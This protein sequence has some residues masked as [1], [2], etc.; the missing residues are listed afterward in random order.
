MATSF[1]TAGSESSEVT[2]STAASTLPPSEILRVSPGKYAGEAIQDV[3]DSES[4]GDDASGEQS[5]SE[6]DSQ[7]DSDDDDDSQSESDSDDDSQSDDEW[8]FWILK[9]KQMKADAERNWHHDT[10]QDKSDPEDEEAAAEDRFIDNETAVNTDLQEDAEEVT[11]KAVQDSDGY[12][13][14]SEGEGDDEWDS[15][16][17]EAKR[18][19]AEVERNW[20]WYPEDSTLKEE[21]ADERVINIEAAVN[22]DWQ[23]NA[24]EVVKVVQ[25]ND[26]IVGDEDEWNFWILEAKRRKADAERNWYIHI[27]ELYSYTARYESGPNSR[28]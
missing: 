19:K 28:K 14:D 17:L 21:A 26:S 25:D 3:D 20:Y 6:Y 2:H 4:D 15:W 24:E 10:T 1:I 13:D 12:D 22:R 23:V 9:A 5:D 27:L 8:D 16:I 7:S 18:L 11:I